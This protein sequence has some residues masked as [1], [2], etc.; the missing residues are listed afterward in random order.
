MRSW[1]DDAPTGTVILSIE[2]NSIRLGGPAHG[3]VQNCTQNSARGFG[4]GL[5]SRGCGKSKGW[6]VWDYRD[7]RDVEGLGVYGV[8]RV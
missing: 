7:P 2:W 6:E 4:G 3:S 8:H 5:G 1:H